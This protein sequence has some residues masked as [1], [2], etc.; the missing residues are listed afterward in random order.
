MSMCSIEFKNLGLLV[1]L[2][3]LLN[4]ILECLCISTKLLGV[5][6]LPWGSIEV[7]L[8]LK[9]H[10][11]EVSSKL[12][13]NA[14]FGNLIQ[15]ISKGLWEF[16]SSSGLVAEFTELSICQ[17]WLNQPRFQ[18]VPPVL[19]PS[20]GEWH[21]CSLSRDNRWAA[22]AS[23]IEL[24]TRLCRCQFEPNRTTGGKWIV[25]KAPKPINSQ[26]WTSLSFAGWQS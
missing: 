11:K 15:S 8:C 22:F 25:F 5:F 9:P 13:S 6:Y 20:A 1:H 3:K 23:K 2:K 7:M 21:S 14:V 12:E 10:F 4:Q 26:N 24:S 17:S 18:Q 19:K 16:Q